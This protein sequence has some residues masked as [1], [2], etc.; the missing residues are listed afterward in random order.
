MKYRWSGE[1]DYSEQEVRQRLKTYFEALGFQCLQDAPELAFQRGSLWRGVFALSPRQI[2]MQITA[3][4]QPWGLHTL[5]DVTFEI[6]PRLRRLNER[7]AELLVS[8]TREMVRYLQEGNADFE[9]L[10]TLHQQALSFRRRGR[11]LGIGFFL[12]GFCL[13]GATKPLEKLSTYWG[14]SSADILWLILG[15]AV[16]VGVGRWFF[17]QLWSRRR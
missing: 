13:G 14:L 7:E 9:R 11:W 17:S 1:V 12:I 4:V 10:E 3:K 6:V 8:E 15:I 2:W 5:I 16:G